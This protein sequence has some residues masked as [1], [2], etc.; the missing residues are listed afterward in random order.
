MRGETMLQ[1]RLEISWL[2][3]F[4][5][6]GDK[7]PFTCCVTEW[8]INLMDN[9]IEA[10]KKLN[11]P[12]RDEILKCI[13]FEKKC[14]KGDE[15]YRCKLLTK[16]GLC[17]IVQ[18]VGPQALSFTCQHFPREIY[19]NGDI[20]ESGVEAACPVV[21]ERLFE[22]ELPGFNY[23]EINVNTEVESYDGY[24][25]YDALVIAR[26]FLLNLFMSGENDEVY[27]KVFILLDMISALKKMTDSEEL[28]PEN[29]DKLCNQY[30]S[31][32][33]IM[34]I[35]N[36]MKEMQY[37]VSMDKD[38]LLGLFGLHRELL[39]TLILRL[40]LRF[41]E[42]ELNRYIS[43][44]TLLADSINRLIRVCRKDYSAF[45]RNFF[46]NKIFLF[47]IPKKGEEFGDKILNVMNEL[48][49]IQFFA[50]MYFDQNNGIS[51]SEYALIITKIDRSVAHSS[52]A[53]EQ[54]KELNK[55]LSVKEFMDLLM[56]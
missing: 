39:N 46:I 2:T 36:T 10:Y 56:F 37:N 26:N 5:C 1:K 33:L 54:L 44:F 51:L 55:Q 24:S 3:E 17:K 18:N 7:C 14:F 52:K 34:Q 47:F 11:H 50:A 40:S 21:T 49:L 35:C 38:K 6:T 31:E 43:D 15:N 13:D 19:I 23:S 4:K 12:Y 16:E 8:G 27:G 29:V 28:N 32:A 9:E 48:F 30:D 42:M 25:T 53:F 41:K 22:E 45:L 20:F